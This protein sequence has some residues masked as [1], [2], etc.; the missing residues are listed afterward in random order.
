MLVVA[1]VWWEYSLIVFIYTTT[2]HA[3]SFIISVAP[4]LH[5]HDNSMASARKKK[6]F[7]GVRHQQRV[8]REAL[9]NIGSIRHPEDEPV[10]V[11]S[12][13]TEYK[14]VLLTLFYILHRN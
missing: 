10:V 14:I 12:T 13:D 6:T 7:V 11:I 5:L 8:F 2:N 1:C 4:V 9:L 3:L